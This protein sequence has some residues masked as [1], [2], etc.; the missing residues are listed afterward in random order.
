MEKELLAREIEKIAGQ[1]NV[2]LDEP[3]KNHTSFKVG[4]PAD[5]L[6]TPVSVSQLS[7]I[8]KLCK[9]KS[10]PVFVMGN[11]TNLIVRDK[12]IK[13]VVVK[14]FDNL[15]QFTVKDDIITAYAGILLSRVSTIAYENGLTGLEFACGIPGTL[16]GAVAMNAGAYGGEMKDVVVETEYMDKDGEIRVVR[17][18]GH[19]FGY[20]TS[21][22]QKNSGIVIKTSMKLKKGN[23]E[24]IKALMDDLTQRRQEKQ[25]LEMPSAGSIFKRPEGYFAGKLIEDCGLRGHRIGGAEVSQK[26]CGFI[27]NTGDAKAK[28]ILDLIEYIRNTVKMKFGVDMQTEVRIV[29]EV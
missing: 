12:G 18:D 4:G 10:V 27:V 15:N 29:G 22:I 24:E 19:Q 5:I 9:N 13:G 28:D 26:H 14:I 8:L 16:G 6:V 17:D 2:K 7:Q 11:G 3:M 23:K 1:E 25:P 20:R 21:F